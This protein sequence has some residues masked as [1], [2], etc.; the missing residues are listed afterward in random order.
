MPSLS[1][2]PEI[3]KK[4]IARTLVVF[5]SILLGITAFSSYHSV[6]SAD[7]GP[8]LIVQNISLSPENPAIDDTVTI[9]VTIKNQGTATAGLSNVLCYADSTIL[10]TKSIDPLNAGVMMTVVFTWKAVEGSHTIKAVAD[11]SG[12]ITETDENNNTKT[13]NLTTQ[14]AD[15]II[16]SITW[17]P[18][19]PSKGDSI[20]FSITIKNQGSS[21]SQYTKVNFSIDENSRGFRDIAAINPGGTLTATYT[22]TAISGQH[23]LKAVID[24]PNNVK[25]SDETNNEL[26]VTFS[27]LPP[28]LTILAITWLPENPS[29]D[30]N[31]TFTANVTNQG[32]GRSDP[33]HLAYD[34][35]GVYQSSISVGAMNAGTSA[36]I[37]FTW[38]ATAEAHEIKVI[39]DY[40]QKVT[41]SDETNNEKTASLQT[42]APDLLVNDITWLP[43]VAGVG[44]NVTFTI[45]IKNQGSGRAAASRAVCYIDGQAVGYPDILEIASEAQ[46]TATILWVA[47]GGSHAVSVQ[48]DYDNR[49]IESNK[50]NNKLTRT[51]SII[52]PDL[53]ISSIDYSPENPTTDDTVTF[54]ITVKNQGGGKA[55][56]FKLACYIDDTLLNL[57]HIYSLA[58]DNSID[59]TSTW[60]MQDG[61]H[62]FKAYANYNKSIAESD[63][64][65]N[66]SSITI[67]PNM[68]DLTITNITWSP[69]DIPAGSD[70]TFDINIENQGSLS[71]GPSRI[72]YY[73]DGANVGYKDIGQLDAGGTTTEHFLWAAIEGQHTIGIAVDSNNQIS[74][75]DENNNTREL[76]LP[77]PDLVVQDITYSP[78]DAKIGD[79]VIITATIKN[80]GSSKTQKSQVACN[81]DGLPFASKDLPEINAGDMVTRTFNWVAEAGIHN[82]KIS[83]D[84]N[85]LVIE[86]DETN[87]DKEIKFATLT[88]DLVIQ[89]IGWLIENPMTNDDVY[90]TITI[91]NQGTGIAGSSRL[92]YSIDQNPALLADITPIPAGDIAEYKFSSILEG[93]SHTA[94]VTI[95][96]N[97]AV[98]ELDEN[99]NNKV[100]SFTTIAPDLI[101]KAI[102][103]A[104]LSANVGDNVTITVKV[105]NRGRDKALNPRLALSVDGSPL[106]S[107]DIPKIDTG[108][109]ITADFA[110]KAMT[111]PHEISAFIDTDQTVLES[112]ETNNTKSRTITIEKP[113]TPAAKKVKL[114]A[115]SSADKGFLSSWWWMFLIVA[116]LL[117]GMAFASALKNLKRK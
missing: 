52:P 60:K 74:E 48:A 49:L 99:N 41:E 103:C 83:T 35:D 90:F 109:I 56:N 113:E 5:L 47:E 20:V 7:T 93:G 2:C 53:V 84:A 16:Q 37:T 61:R 116:A 75:Y 32:S 108:A 19:S 89:N 22:W 107:F 104:P 102:T 55:E 86:S 68:P 98:T 76:N 97:N 38:I 50:D 29:K 43:S 34:I 78:L 11:S 82:I 71:A 62:I 94:N 72:A 65:N 51:I 23:S 91:K 95:D 42:L 85:N 27:T 96:A 25:E 13:F 36:N 45:T 105:E 12:F 44:D 18:S 9:T 63:E 58:S 17:S 77:P 79:S 59:E 14:A 30:D 106:G 67:T 70:I 39:I 4:I 40:Y 8:D 115:T 31:V 10:D 112:N 66:E 87:N 81:I 15:L 26:T 114:P 73:V 1:S 92:K 80:Q 3:M 46:A 111:G 24:E 33:C 110:W 21:K 117:G 100:L 57:E 54:T 6:A 69:P 101:I 28:D 88:P 64:N